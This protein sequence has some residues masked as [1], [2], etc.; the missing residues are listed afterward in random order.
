M[1]RRGFAR[2]LA[3]LA[4]PGG[5]SE[6][7]LAQ[8]ALAGVDLAP[9]MI[10]L[11]ANEN[12]EGPSRRALEAMREVLPHAWRY[13]FQEFGDFCAAVARSEG[14]DREQVLVGAGSSEILHAAIDAFTAPDRPLITMWPTFE[15]P[16]GI[17]R[18]LGRPVIRVPLTEGYAADVKA[19]VAA[20]ENSRGG[21]IYLCNPNNPTGAY[22]PKSELDWLAANLPVNTVLLVDEAYIHFAEAADL[23]TA[24]AYVE[25]GKDV[26]VART[27]SKIYGLAGLRV[28]FGCAKPEL[29]RRMEPFRDNVISIVGARAARAALEEASTLVPERRART[30]LLRDELY[31][32]LERHGF[33]FIASQANFVMI[34]VGRDVRELLPAMYRRG[35]APGRHFPP[36]DHMLRVTIGTAAE[37]AKFREVL[38]E[39]ARA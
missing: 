13:H 5:W 17:T 1:T 4:A 24:I 18:A 35:V 36:L 26:V 28:G 29:I 16:E 25:Q 31:V 11:N 34:D 9:D 22:T 3:A 15:A 39:V 10:W 2:A 33:G 20:A 38:L 7:A 14:L 19:L 6:R 21:L 37:M 8:R 30:A 12:P 32:W 27:F 23:A